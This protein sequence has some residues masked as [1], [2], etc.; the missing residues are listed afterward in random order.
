MTTTIETAPPENARNRRT[1][2]SP[3]RRTAFLGGLFYLITFAS[4]I[5]AVLLLRPVLNDENFIISA[6]ANTQ[7]L[8][9]CI[10]DIVNALAAV[11][12]AVVLFPVVKRQSEALALGFVTSRMLEAAVIAIGV[13]SLLTIVSLQQPGATGEDA[14]SL[15][16]TGQALV[17]ARDWTFLL[18]P[19]IMAGLNALLLGTLMYK[20]GLVPRI[21]PTMGLIGGPLLLA[22]TVATIL[23]LTEHGSAWWIV[24]FPLILWE[25]SLGLY[26]AFK[27]FKPSPI[28]ADE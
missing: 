12:S 24:S 17:A 27:G 4:S 23:G 6:G 21:I 20:S 11:G 26:L 8:W 19:N 2:M 3:L 13:V 9:G 14:H 25:L 1:R 7:V 18:G 22:V 16:M 15:V 28:T 5:P 10:L